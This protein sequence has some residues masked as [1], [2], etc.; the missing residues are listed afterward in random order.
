MT[1]T[2]YPESPNHGYGYG[3]VNAFDAV[4]SVVSGLGYVEGQVTKEGDEPTD[5]T[6]L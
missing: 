6:G 1:N 4:S 5:I 3:L 2:E